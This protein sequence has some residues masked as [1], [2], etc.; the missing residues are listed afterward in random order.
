[1]VRCVVGAN[2]MSS[3][4]RICDRCG[5]RTSVDRV[6]FCWNCAEKLPTGPRAHSR[7]AAVGKTALLASVLAAVAAVAWWA[8]PL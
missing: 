4:K 5:A 6:L 2:G 7:T 3:T 1:M 8:V